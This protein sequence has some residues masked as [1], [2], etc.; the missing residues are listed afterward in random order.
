M[1]HIEVPAMLRLWSLDGGVVREVRIIEA[2]N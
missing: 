1:Q 2:N